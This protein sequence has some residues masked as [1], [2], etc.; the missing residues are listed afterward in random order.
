[1][2]RLNA[3]IHALPY[4]PS[5]SKTFRAVHRYHVKY[6]ARKSNRISERPADIG[7]ARRYWRNFANNPILVNR[8][9]ISEKGW[10]VVARC[11]QRARPA[12]FALR[13]PSC[14]PAD[15]ERQMTLGRDERVKSTGLPGI[16]SSASFVLA[17]A[18]R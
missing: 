14:P 9:S 16:I 13:L 3:Q 7:T 12:S 18:T 1:M 6:I 2:C 11:F 10:P 17:V 8:R 4:P 15:T 5:L